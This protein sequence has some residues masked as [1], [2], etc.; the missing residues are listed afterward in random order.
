MSPANPGCDRF[1]A[2]SIERHSGDAAA[3]GQQLLLSLEVGARSGS[4]HGPLM[5]E[6]PAARSRQL[7]LAR[8][9]PRLGYASLMQIVRRRRAAHLSLYPSRLQCVGFD[10]FPAASDSKCQQ[11]IAQLALRVSR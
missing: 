2:W 10:V 11:N 6:I 7:V 4:A 5:I 1:V 8:G 9:K 3:L